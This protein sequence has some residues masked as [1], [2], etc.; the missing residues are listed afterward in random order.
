MN[1]PKEIH[2]EVRRTN[3]DGL[4]YDFDCDKSPA[5]E[6]WELVFKA[7]IDMEKL[8]RGECPEDHVANLLMMAFAEGAKYGRSKPDQ[9]VFPVF[10]IS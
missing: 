8:R 3:N 7:K 5:P 1:E 9:H 10:P 6:E 4:H 2:V